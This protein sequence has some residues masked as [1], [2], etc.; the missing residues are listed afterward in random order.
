MAS[1]AWSSKGLRVLLPISGLLLVLQ[2]GL[3]LWTNA[4]APASGFTGSTSFAAYSA[5]IAVGFLLGLFVLLVLVF[6]LLTKEPRTIVLS[7]VLFVSVAIAGVAGHLF[8]STTPNPPIESVVMGLAFLVAFW[9]GVALGLS[10]MMAR[11]GASA[12]PTGP[13]LAA[14]PT[15]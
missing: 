3:G 1:P 5:H 12:P 9:C 2:Y 14:P 4:Y 10:Q 13:A 6:A 11:R 8:V 15:A 7:A